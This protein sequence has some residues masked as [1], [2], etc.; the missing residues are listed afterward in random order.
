MLRSTISI[1]LYIE[2]RF[3]AENPRLIRLCLMQQSHQHLNGFIQDSPM[4]YFFIC[5]ITAD[6][7]ALI[8][9]FQVANKTYVGI[10]L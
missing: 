6:Y 5:Q 9:V 8:R 2:Y 10:D 7:R 4:N 1:A 3:H